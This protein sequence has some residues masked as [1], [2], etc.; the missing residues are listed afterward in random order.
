MEQSA[1]IL[2]RPL[3]QF[4]LWL[5]FV[6]YARADPRVSCVEIYLHRSISWGNILKKDWNVKWI[7]QLRRHSEPSN[8]SLWNLR[9]ECVKK[10]VIEIKTW[11][12]SWPQH[13]PRPARQSGHTLSRNN[14]NLLPQLSIPLRYGSSISSV[15]PPQPGG[16]Q[17]G[18]GRGWSCWIY[19]ADGGRRHYGLAQ[20]MA[21][22]WVF[23][24]S[25]KGEGSALYF[26]LSAG[27]ARTRNGGVKSKEKG[28]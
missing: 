25:K 14:N 9:V 21:G 28:G 12:S 16:R 18:R 22:K 2:F 4:R 15:P 5:F 8:S 6:F 26:T 7:R 19:R 24:S 3:V 23:F 20:G 1:V 11:F 17:R 13:L 10:K 27:G